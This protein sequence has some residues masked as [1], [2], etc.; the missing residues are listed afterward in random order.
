MHGRRSRELGRKKN[1]FE[2]TQIETKS[3]PDRPRSAENRP[4]GHLGRQVDQSGRAGAAKSTSQGVQG[5]FGQPNRT[6]QRAQIDEDRPKTS[7]SGASGG[8][9]DQSGRPGASELTTQGDQGRFGLISGSVAA[10]STCNPYAPARTDRM[11]DLFRLIGRA[12]SKSIPCRPKIDTRSTQIGPK[13]ATRAPRAAKSARQGD[14]GRP[15][16]PGRATRGDSGKQIDPR[17]A[18]SPGPGG[19][20]TENLDRDI[21]IYM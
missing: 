8:Q 4:I 1:L 11:S 15:S 21:Y 2:R 13:R 5:R 12:V 14:Q 10:A 6:P 16:R 19:T 9:I 7:Q 20:S 18:R 3:I 17:C